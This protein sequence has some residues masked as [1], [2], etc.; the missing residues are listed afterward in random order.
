MNEKWYVLKSLRNQP[1]PFSE[2]LLSIQCII[3]FIKTNIR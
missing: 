3:A 2:D 1:M